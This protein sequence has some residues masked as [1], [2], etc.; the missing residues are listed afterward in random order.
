M[1]DI[2]GPDAAE[3]V[4][5]FLIDERLPVAGAPS[6]PAGRAAPALGKLGSLRTVRRLAALVDT[7]TQARDKMVIEENRGR[8]VRLPAASYGTTEF[9]MSDA[10]RLALIAAAEAATVAYLDQ[11]AG[12]LESL[13]TLSTAESDRIALEELG[14]RNQ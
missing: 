9:G 2:M 6:A 5:G 13:E 11:A 14:I 8:V 12:G 7:V 3:G 1:R 10:R 4:L